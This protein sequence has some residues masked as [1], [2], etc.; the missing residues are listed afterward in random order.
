MPD[1]LVG[2]EI[3]DPDGYVLCLNQCGNVSLGLLLCRPEAEV[4]LGAVDPTGRCPG[5]IGGPVA[6]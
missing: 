4:I 6:G 5:R 1:G 2:F 3:A